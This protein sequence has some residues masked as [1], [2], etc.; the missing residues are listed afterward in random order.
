M[1]LAAASGNVASHSP[2]PAWAAYVSV[3]DR[4]GPPIS[5]ARPGSTA[6]ASMTRP[7]HPQPQLRRRGRCA[8][9]SNGACK[10]PVAMH[11]AVRS[12][13]VPLPRNRRGTRLR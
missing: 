3:W 5:R 9:G 6:P 2:E 10:A 4:K 12:G 8:P 13:A 7:R 11:R 1:T